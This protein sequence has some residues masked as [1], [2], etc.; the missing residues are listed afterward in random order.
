METTV[1]VLKEDKNNLKNEEKSIDKIIYKLQK[2]VFGK[3][4]INNPIEVAKN[5]HSNNY[6]NIANISQLWTLKKFFETINYPTGIIDIGMRFLKEKNYHGA[7]ESFSSITYTPGLIELT[8]EVVKEVKNGNRNNIGYAKKALVDIVN[9][10]G[11]KNVKEYID[12]IANAY[13]L[14]YKDNIKKTH[15]K[16][17]NYLFEALQLYKL[18]NNK[19]GILKIS[20]RIFYHK[21]SH[22]DNKLSDSENYLKII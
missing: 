9:S 1:K 4:K 2:Y 7:Y 15:H 6:I 16:D 12:T 22:E 20:S 18:S 17:D 5:L 21:F 19:I 13:F 3:L 11:N 14:E 10:E 8:K